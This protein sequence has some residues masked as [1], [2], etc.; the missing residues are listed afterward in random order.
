MSGM[1]DLDAAIGVVVLHGGDFLGAANALRD[2]PA[3]AQGEPVAWPT[4][5][6]S[7]EVGA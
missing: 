6:L 3:A 4:S 5:A 2:L 7:Q 1:I